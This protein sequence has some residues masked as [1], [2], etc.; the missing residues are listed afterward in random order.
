ME[1]GVFSHMVFHNV[2]R[3]TGHLS[4]NG[5]YLL[6]FCC[7]VEIIVFILVLGFLATFLSTCVCA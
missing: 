6:K 7:C 4:A 5:T 2:L 1:R 3:R